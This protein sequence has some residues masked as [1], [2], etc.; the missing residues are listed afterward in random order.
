MPKPDSLMP[1]EERRRAIAAILARGVRALWSPPLSLM[2][3][4]A[5]RSTKGRSGALEWSVGWLRDLARAWFWQVAL[6]M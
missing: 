1:P 5:T 6:A 3:P 4:L 2:S